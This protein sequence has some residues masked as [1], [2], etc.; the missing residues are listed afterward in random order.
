MEEAFLRALHVE[1]G[2]ETTWLALADWLDEDGQ[3][4]RAELVRLVRRLRSLAMT[5]FAPER[6]Q[7]QRRVADLL[8][9][10][11]PPVVPEIVNSIGMRLALVPAGAFLMGSTEDEQQ[12][13]RRHVR[14]E[15]IPPL[16]EQ[17]MP[18]WKAEGPQHRVEIS[19][20]FYLG[21]FPVTQAQWRAVMGNNPSCFCATGLDKEKVE[22]ISTDDFPVECVSWEDAMHFLKTL[23]ERKEE[24]EEGRKYRLPT[25]AEWEYACR[26]GTASS[27]PFHFGNSLS[28]SQAN[29]NGDS[30]YG[31]ASKGLH[32]KRT[33]KVGEY[34]PNAVGLYDMHGNVEEWCSDWHGEDYYGK[35][36]ERDP[37]G[38]G[39]GSG[40]VIR[41]GCWSALG[42]YCRSASRGGVVVD[43]PI[44][45]FGFRAA[46][47]LCEG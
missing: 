26:G 23:S 35:S 18:N 16:P 36:P 25:E 15:L 12:E 43:L 42:V 22:G 10:G 37:P 21:V 14:E 39:E 6:D 46:L 27:S 5:R 17:H 40:R 44:Q 29:F 32:L 47:D 45:L 19:K 24:R 11:V 28:S 33:C 9:S 30:P 31:G 2:D 20:P 41:G 3:S 7:M 38:P 13:A 34:K 8:N 4:E 1:P